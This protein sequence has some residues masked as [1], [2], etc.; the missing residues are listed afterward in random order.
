MPRLF[1]QLRYFSAP[2]GSC[3]A[4][5]GSHSIIET[6]LAVV[7]SVKWYGYRFTFD[8]VPVHLYITWDVDSQRDN[9][10]HV[11]PLT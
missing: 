1:K 4:L 8:I 7:F 10:V 9:I 6:N 2:T 5:N 11:N 3:K